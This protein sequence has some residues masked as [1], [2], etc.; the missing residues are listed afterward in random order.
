MTPREELTDLLAR[1][2]ADA[3]EVLSKLTHD[4]ASDLPGSRTELISVV[5]QLGEPQVHQLLAIAQAMALPVEE[6]INPD[7]SVVTLAFA[8]EFRARLQAHHGTHTT[9]MDRLSFEN[10][11]LAASRAAGRATQEAPSRTT[12]FFDATVDRE[13]TALKFEGAKS[14]KADRL[15]ISKLSE[16]AW[17]QDMRSA[18]KRRDMTMGLLDDFLAAVRRMFVLRFYQFD[19]APH[20]ELVEIPVD[21][22]ALVRQLPLSEFAS[23][24]P[25][26][27]IAD[28]TGPIMEFHLDRSDSKITVGKIE[29]SRCTVHGEWRLTG[30]GRTPSAPVA[31]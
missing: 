4:L 5:N 8:G 25:R 31:Q 29:K 23:D 3:R 21:Y 14:M 19:P 28:D 6:S 2:G 18:R 15:H 12:R 27:K 1:L 24:A 22:F 10:A 9:P 16:A 26:L 13:H 17:I 7:S 30:I 20:Y 11:F